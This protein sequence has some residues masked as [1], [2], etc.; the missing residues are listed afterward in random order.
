MARRLS[1]AVESWPIRGAF[2]IARGAKTEA[3]VVVAT[4]ADGG[5]IGRGECVPYGRYGESAESV[6]AEIES[7]RPEMERG[8][9]REMLQTRMKAGAARNALDC[10]LID[11]EAKATGRRAFEILNLPAPG[12][13]ATAFTLSVDR[14]EVM[15]EAARDA[16]AKQ[17]RLLKLKLAGGEDLARVEAVRRAAPK[18]RLIV[19]A[20]ESLT[21]DELRRLAPE[22]AKLGVVLIEQ[23]LKAAEDE[24]LAGLACAVPLCADES[25]H[26]RADLERL[27][28]R[29][30]HINIK[31]D[32]AG[33]LTEALALSRA[34]TAMGFGL[35][36]GCMVSTSLAMAP[37]Q[38]LA[39]MAAFTDLDGPLLLARDREPALRYEEDLLHPAPAALW[40]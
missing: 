2:R 30:S 32:K 7:L 28:G 3:L 15:A 11:W 4:L 37:A 9:T 1:V 34:A 26:T 20:N 6:S 25:C 40:G 16:A 31:L 14:P 18:A 24:A 22:L 33:G 12:P 39:V 21:P 27:S 8:L 38:L 13:V 23:P 17:Y 35:M 19:D 10:A 36:V 29:Y 5:A